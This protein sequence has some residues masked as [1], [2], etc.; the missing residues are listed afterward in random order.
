MDKMADDVL[1]EKVFNYVCGSDGFVEI[2]VLLKSSSPLGSRKTELEARNWFK[3]QTDRRLAEVKDS[4]GETAGMRIDLRRKLCRQ[5]HSKGSCRSAHG[6]CKFWHICKGFMEDN[7]LG[8][9]SR[10]HNFLDEE[11]YEKTKGLGLDKHPNGTIKNIVQWS[12]PQ[13]CE[14]YSRGQC[15]QRE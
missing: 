5:Y 11:N 15:S 2:S 12:L 8:E 7:C 10:S 14:R 9:C 1:A 3:K 6:K 4:K 13:V